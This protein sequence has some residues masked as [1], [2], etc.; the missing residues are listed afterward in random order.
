MG[1][2]DHVEGDPFDLHRHVDRPR[3]FLREVPFGAPRFDVLEIGLRVALDQL[4]SAQAE[5][6][7]SLPRAVGAVPFLDREQGGLLQQ[8][9]ADRHRRRRCRSARR[10]RLPRR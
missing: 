8:C 4:F 1:Q 5:L 3:P 10:R 9:S 6:V 7:R 2:D